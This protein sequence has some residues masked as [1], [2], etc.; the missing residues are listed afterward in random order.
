VLIHPHGSTPTLHPKE[1]FAGRPYPKLEPRNHWFDFVDCCLASDANKKPTANFDYAGPLTEAVLLGGVASRFP[2]TT[3]QWD[4]K[5]LKF[6]ET[7]ANQYVRRA[8]RDGWSIK[9]LS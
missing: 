4:S 2:K 5:A 7:A 3:L 8:Y 6:S 1:K 9:G